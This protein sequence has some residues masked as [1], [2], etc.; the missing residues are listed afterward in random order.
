[1]ANEEAFALLESI[2]DGD[3]QMD[4]QMVYAVVRM[5][6]GLTVFFTKSLLGEWTQSPTPEQHAELIRTGVASL[7]ASIRPLDDGAS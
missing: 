6:T 1:M 3:D 7:N 4:H 2:S 5:F